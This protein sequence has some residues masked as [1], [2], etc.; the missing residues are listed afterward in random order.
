MIAYHL[1]E[2]KRPIIDFVLAGVSIFIM[3]GIAPIVAALELIPNGFVVLMICP[4]AFAIFV[5]L[6]HWTAN[7]LWK[8]SLLQSYTRV[9]DLN[10]HWKGHIVQAYNRFKSL[11]VDKR[12]EIPVT[13]E[14]E[15]DLHRISLR[16]YRDAQEMATRS[17]A[18]A[19]SIDNGHRWDCYLH[20]AFDVRFMPEDKTYSGVCNLE[21]RTPADTLKGPYTSSRGN[22][23]TLYLERNR[24][25]A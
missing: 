8:S 24:Q 25:T 6:R 15:Q 16:L 14:I 17:E 10:G 13:C 7:E 2:D 22:C 3:S 20:Y 4:S 12:T 1:A 18:I 21:F 5:L 11:P 19:V 9:P 23:G